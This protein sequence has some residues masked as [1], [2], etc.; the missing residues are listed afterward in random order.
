M[1]SSSAY[2][3]FYKRRDLTDNYDFKKVL[4]ENLDKLE[5]LME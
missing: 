3:L 2:V 5:V 1:I 4:K